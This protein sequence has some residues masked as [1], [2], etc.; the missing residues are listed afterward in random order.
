MDA[1]SSSTRALT[2]EEKK[3]LM[4]EEKMK[5]DGVESESSSSEDG[6]ENDDGEEGESE[7][8]DSDDEDDDEEDDS[9]YDGQESE[10]SSDDEEAGGR[11]KGKRAK[12]SE[13]L[14]GA[15][16]FGIDEDEVKALRESAVEMYGEGVLGEGAGDGVY[17]SGMGKEEIHALW[18]TMLEEAKL[19]VSMRALE[20]Q[21]Q[22]ISA[23]MLDGSGG[24]IDAQR[25]ASLV[26]TKRRRHNTTDDLNH[27]DVILY[28]ANKSITGNGQEQ[29]QAES[30]KAVLDRVGAIGLP[31]DVGGPGSSFIAGRTSSSNGAP[32]AAKR[33]QVIEASQ[34]EKEKNRA[35]A[36]ALKEKLAS[37]GFS[38][39]T[40]SS[41]SSS[42]SSDASTSETSAPYYV[43]CSTTDVLSKKR[44]QQRTGGEERIKASGLGLWMPTRSTTGTITSSLSSF[45]DAACK[46][47]EDDNKLAAAGGGGS[48]SSSSSSSSAL[49]AAA[50][51]L[52]EKEDAGTLLQR[53]H[54][55]GV[56]ISADG[57]SLSSASLASTDP[58]LAQR[59]LTAAASAKATL[60]GRKV[61]VKQ[62][63]KFAG[64]TITVTRL[65][66]AGTEAEKAAKAKVEAARA[67]AEQAAQQLREQ[68]QA[69]GVP[70]LP[71]GGVAGGLGGI[72][73]GLDRT[74]AISTLAKSSLDWDQYKMQR[75]IEDELAGAAKEGVGFVG[76]QAFLARVDARQDEK[77]VA[78]RQQ[79]RAARFAAQAA[80]GR[81]GF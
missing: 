31:L 46:K 33:R 15:V 19:P 71:T 61:A 58:A 81:G 56:S 5:E 62:T 10:A 3:K 17:V 29:E 42:S 77:V 39:P 8:D 48:S 36:E 21:Q 69:A 66:D 22:A 32:P 34:L 47:E 40:S 26:G 24:E 1:T 14:E 43:T 57:S 54:H 7:E 73:A 28:K 67:K 20:Q 35:I 74:E 27:I 78:K 16:D 53:L 9:S 30:S 2:E 63:V 68:Q 38:A 49:T 44:Q 55:Q 50:K 79:E 59:L 6:D 60:A 11:G 80:Q 64:Q 45:I 12:K 4:R 65:V 76:K 70:V 18:K 13:G 51:H 52:E 23:A 72:L 75:G 37:N 41:S 25:L